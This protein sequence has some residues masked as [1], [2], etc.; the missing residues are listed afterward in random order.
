M[1]NS[2]FDKNKN[3]KEMKE[4]KV[5]DILRPQKIKSLHDEGVAEY[6]RWAVK[7]KSIEQITDEINS[8]LTP[9]AKKVTSDEVSRYYIELQQTSKNGITKEQL[10]K[11]ITAY[12]TSQNAFKCS[13]YKWLQKHAYILGDLLFKLKKPTVYGVSIEIFKRYNKVIATRCI[14]KH[15]QKI[16]IYLPMGDRQKAIQRCGTYYRQRLDKA[17]NYNKNQKKGG[18]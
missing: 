4:E 6:L 7:C 15:F 18:K 16:G 14:A 2:K 12:L 13:D 9:R 1:N 11:M 3:L 5:M 17:E 10:K 8:S